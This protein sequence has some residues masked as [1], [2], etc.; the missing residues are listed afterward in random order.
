MLPV[1][2]SQKPPARVTTL[3]LPKTLRAERRGKFIVVRYGSGDAQPVTLP[4]R[5]GFHIGAKTYRDGMMCQLSSAP[6]KP[7]DVNPID[8]WNEDA[9]SDKAITYRIEVF[10]TSERAGHMWRPGPG[11]G[12][13]KVLWSKSFIV[14][15]SAK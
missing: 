6:P 5:N 15:G 4:L 3:Q 2:S 10:E 12:G 11:S 9:D 7:D 1:V 13:Y 14:S 8:M